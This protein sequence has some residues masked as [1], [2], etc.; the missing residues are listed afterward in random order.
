MAL[1]KP[2]DARRTPVLSAHGERQAARE[3][4]NKRLDVHRKANDKTM[5][6]EETATLRGRIA[7]CIA[8]MAVL[9]PEE[10]NA[11]DHKAGSY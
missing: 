10:L 6:A 7:E 11:P 4:L 1:E 2:F 5:T 8:I 9:D 3:F